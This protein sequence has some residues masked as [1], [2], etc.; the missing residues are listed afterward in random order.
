MST[1]TVRYWT[2]DNGAITCEAHAGNYL[3]CGIAASPKAT[4]HHTPL[5]TFELLTDDEVVEFQ[6]F[7]DERLGGGSPCETCRDRMEVA[8]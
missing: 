1:T 3:T 4:E 7:L 5:G 8:R 2:D 6:A